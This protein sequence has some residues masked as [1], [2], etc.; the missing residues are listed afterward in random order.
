MRIILNTLTAI[1]LFTLSF[2]ALANKQ[3]EVTQSNSLLYQIGAIL[4]LNTQI[5][6]K[7]REH[8]KVVS[9]TDK[10]CIKTLQGPHSDQNIAVHGT[11][12]LKSIQCFATQ[13]GQDERHFCFDKPL[14]ELLLYRH[15]ADN[16]E[17][18]TVLDTNWRERWAIKKNELSWPLAKLP[19]DTAQSYRSYT[20]KKAGERIKL[21]FHYL[22]ETLSASEKAMVL[23]ECKYQ[24]DGIFYID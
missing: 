21:H 14:K 15:Q 7:D 2:S 11:T 18:V 3:Y 23:H 24:K 17:E 20:F 5:R 19:V 1:S 4:G 13:R 12:F 10:S 6:L 16:T 9:T 22:S 8:I